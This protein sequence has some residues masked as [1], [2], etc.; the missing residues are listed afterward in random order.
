[1]IP[2]TKSTFINRTKSL[3][4]REPT[5]EEFDIFS[6]LV[7]TELGLKWTGDKKYVLYARLQRRLQALNLTTFRDYHDYLQNQNNSVELQKLF[8]AV[9]TTK[10]GFYRE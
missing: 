3:P 8:N 9:T 10:T 1:M 2:Q 6:K 7:L 4:V 5:D